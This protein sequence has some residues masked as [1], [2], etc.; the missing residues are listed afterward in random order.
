MYKI[1]N[2]EAPEYLTN[3]LPNRVGEQTHYHLR[4]NQNFEVPYSRLCSYENSFFPSTLRLWNDLDFATLNSS[5]LLEF[6]RKIKKIQEKPVNYIVTGE[7]VNEIALTRIKHNCSSLKADL[8]RVNIVPSAYCS[9]GPLNETAEHYFF[10][11][12]LYNIPRN[13]L[14]TSL[15]AVPITLN[16]LLYGHELLTPETN[17]ATYKSVLQSVKD[18]GRYS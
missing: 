16:T 2:N 14:L 9:C 4:N 15:S 12:A 5:S 3:L 7:R 10:D 18:T 11:C 8:F 17:Q 1:I 13:R 6:K